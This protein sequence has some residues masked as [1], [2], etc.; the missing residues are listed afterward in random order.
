M[1]LEK[2]NI[3][4]YTLNGR[5]WKIHLGRDITGA[6][7]RHLSRVL[8]ELVDARKYGREPGA[9]ALRQLARIEDQ[10][11]QRMLRTRGL[12]PDRQHRTLREWLVESE[13]ERP[14]LR[15][16]SLKKLQ[17]TIRWIRDVLGDRLEFELRRLG[18]QD[19]D[20]IRDDGRR[21]ER[22]RIWSAATLRVH[23]GNCR[24]IFNR[25]V[26]AELMER[27]PFARK[28]LPTGCKARADSE[29]VPWERVEAVIARMTDPADQLR[30]AL[31]RLAGLRVPSESATL[32]VGDVRSDRLRVTDQKRGVNREPPIDPRLSPY[33]EAATDGHDASALICPGGSD[34][35]YTRRVQAAAKAAGVEL[36][37]D[38]H[39]SLRASCEIDWKRVHPTADVMKWIGHSAT[40]SN[41]S[42]DTRLPDEAYRQFVDRERQRVQSGSAGVGASGNVPGSIRP[43]TRRTLSESGM[44]RVE[45]IHAG[46][47]K[48]EAEGIEPSSQDNPDDGLYML[49]R[50]F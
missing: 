47:L 33:L 1:G 4:R 22:G 50:M 21:R 10:R 6:N 25:A 16:R 7:A 41:R 31:G 12:F 46:S 44:N 35:A 32:R 43:E 14:G 2:G 39:Q 42:Y 19:A 49:S 24:S 29:Y 27:N 5:R 30:L 45:P 20:R 9:D 48:V 3:Y 13:Q 40:V 17:Q 11:L 15:A 26:E 34:G 37:P 8:D 18:R 38:L 28:D 23:F 36:W